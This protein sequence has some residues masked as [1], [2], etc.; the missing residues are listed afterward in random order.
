MSKTFFEFI[1]IKIRWETSTESVLRLLKSFSLM[2]SMFMEDARWSCFSWETVW[3]SFERCS[4]APSNRAELTKESSCSGD[5]ISV[6]MTSSFPW[7]SAELEPPASNL[8]QRRYQIV[9]SWNR[10][11][12]IMIGSSRVKSLEYRNDWHKLL[13]H[14]RTGGNHHSEFWLNCLFL[15]NFSSNK[16]HQLLYQQQEVPEWTKHYRIV[17][18]AAPPRLLLL[19]RQT[20]LQ[21]ISQ[22]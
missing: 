1:K 2:C 21:L 11:G 14:S 9:P 18:L 3:L 10:I 19:P 13:W 12:G 20:C 22:T 4:K 16:V 6:L 8:V 15:D 17:Q 5:S 7:P